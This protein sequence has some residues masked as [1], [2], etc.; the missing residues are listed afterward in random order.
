MNSMSKELSN[1][2]MFSSSASELWKDIKEQFEGYSGPRLYELRMSIYSSK[3]GGDSIAMYYNK[4]KRLWDE[5]ACLKPN[6][7]GLYVDEEK[8][9]QFLMG[10]REEYDATRNQVVEQ[11][12]ALQGV[13]LGN[14]DNAVMHTRSYQ[15]G[16]IVGFFDWWPKSTNEGFGRGK[17]SAVNNMVYQNEFNSDHNTPLENV[18]EGKKQWR[19]DSRSHNVLA[20]GRQERGLYVLNFK[21]FSPSE[22][23][24]FNFMSSNSNSVNN[25]ILSATYV[26]NRLPTPILNWKSPYETLF[27]Q[28][29]NLEHLKVFGCLCF[30][31]CT[32]TH[33]SKF[34]E[35]SHH[36]VIFIGYPPN[37]KSFRYY[38]L[39]TN[40]VSVS[41][42]IK[43]YESIFSFNDSSSSYLSSLVRN[44]HSRPCVLVD[45]YAVYD[46]DVVLVQETVFNDTQITQE[47]AENVPI[48]HESGSSSSSKTVVSRHS[49]RSRKPSVWLNDYVVSSCSTSFDISSFTDAHMLFIANLSIIQEPSTYKQARFNH[50]WIQAMKAELKALEDNN[51][52]E[53]TNLPSGKNTIVC[54]WIYKVKYKADGTIDKYKARLVAKGYNKMEGIDYYESFSPVA[55]TVTVRF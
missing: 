46:Q 48:I 12:R 45:H 54:R 13:D 38:D 40:T 23:Q 27:L 6:I 29:P 43:F 39:M 7:V 17:S 20:L 10:L 52:W 14:A 8:M 37:K 5:L 2:F 16:G 31:T 1:G 32:E 15:N 34:Q 22:I 53:L 51:T 24:H 30:A 49:H 28:P 44:Q 33:K 25:A 26:I 11:Q 55:K 3:K 19:R 47:L 18:M 41:R 4:V 36:P 9:M 35:R 42:D 21:S 50:D